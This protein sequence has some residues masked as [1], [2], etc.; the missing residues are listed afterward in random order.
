MSCSRIAK[1]WKAIELPMQ[2]HLAVRT[3]IYQNL[4]NLQNCEILRKPKETKELKASS[5]CFLSA[6]HENPSPLP[7]TWQSLCRKDTS[8]FISFNS[9][10]SL[11][12]EL[13]SQK[14]HSDLSHKKKS[15]CT[16]VNL[17]AFRV[18]LTSHSSAESLLRSNSKP[19]KVSSYLWLTSENSM[20]F[21]LPFTCQ[22]GCT[23]KVPQIATMK[24]VLTS[25]DG[26]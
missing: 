10:T 1:A 16:F 22:L 26:R 9:S 8:S 13:K 18:S 3:K 5:E 20:C 19:Q 2:H 4:S 23:P 14:N 7:S 12:S 15:S 25:F 24:R 6:G 11:S 21:L 17:K